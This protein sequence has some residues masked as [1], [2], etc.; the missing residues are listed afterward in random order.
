MADQA[1]AGLRDAA[2]LLQQLGVLAELV[3]QVAG[4]LE[5]VELVRGDER[6]ER[7]RVVTDESDHLAIALGSGV[8]RQIDALEHGVQAQMARPIRGTRA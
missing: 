2:D 4:G 5:Q 1:P 8:Q 6:A 7:L 3:E